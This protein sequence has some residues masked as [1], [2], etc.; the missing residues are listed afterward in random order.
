MSIMELMHR[1]KEHVIFYKS[2]V[3]W[4]L[5]RI[6]P[7]TVN[8]D[9]AVPQRHPVTQP[10]TTYVRGTESNSTEAQ[11]AHGATPS[12]GP[13]PEEVSSP[14]EPFASPTADDVR[15][16]PPGLGNTPPEGGGTVLSTKP[17][18]E[19]WL[20]GQHAS[21]TEAITQ[22]VPTIALVVELTSPIILSDQTGG[23]M[24]CT[25]CNCFGEEVEFGR[26]WSHPQGHGDHLSWRS[27]LL[28]SPNGS[29]SPWTC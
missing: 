5:E 26:N 11:E 14:V 17:K 21:P 7:E 4:G 9:L 18:M 2:D 1:M 12:F 8:W 13:P 24:L 23:K 20:T 22:L 3:L 28:E 27:S 15:H 19:D 6:A 10:T 29:S 25:G 16:T